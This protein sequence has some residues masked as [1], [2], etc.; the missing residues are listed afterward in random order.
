MKLK[1]KSPKTKIQPSKDLSEIR[2]YYKKISKSFTKQI[3]MNNP[4]YNAIPDSTDVMPAYAHDYGNY[5][6]RYGMG[7]FQIQVVMKLDGKLDFDMLSR[8]VRLSVDA[9]P[10]LG[11]KFVEHNPPYFKRRED[12]DN[13]K[14]CIMEETENTEE[15][16]HKFLESPLDMDRDFMVKVKL[17]RSGEND[18][19]VVKLNHTCSDGAGT[20]DYILLLSHIYS[21]LYKDGIYVPKPSVRSR[22]DHEKAFKVL[23]IKHPELDPSVVES[24]KTVWPFHW[25]CGGEK[26]ITPFV[27]CQLPN[28]QL[29]ILSKYAKERGATL[30]DLILTAFYR[31]MFKLTN[32]PYGIPMDMGVTIDLRRYLPDNKAEAIRNFS[33]GVV[34][35]IARLFGEPFEGTLMRVKSIMNRKKGKNPGYQSATG[36]ERAEKMDFLKYLAFSKFMSK[37]SEVTSQNCN[38]C[39]PGLS[40]VGIISKSPIKFGEN[41]V[42]EAYFIPPVVRPPAFLLVAS[43]YNGIMTLA[44]GYYKGATSKSKIEKL[45]NK[46]KSELMECCN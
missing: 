30:N 25:K 1:F 39:S 24:P 5:V 37:T 23:G 43:S 6:A 7:N 11:C 34:L 36:A 9:E 22:A 18:T 2:S 28:G 33:G 35:R 17:I 40:N 8:A 3:N 44:V 29:D 16:L 13:S 12:I 32:P 38:F 20:K 26:D 19:L 31:A 46:I 41:A 14:L 45:L 21:C 42:S 15:A 10:V 4:T 27:I